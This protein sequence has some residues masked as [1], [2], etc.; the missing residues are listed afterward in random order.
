ME[1]GKTAKY[2]KY[3]IG[4]IVLV[5]IGILLAL[6]VNNWNEVRKTSIKEVKFLNGF[7]ID[8][9]ANIIELKRVIK[10]TEK[11]F[12]SS[13][14]ILQFQRGD[15]D[16]LHLQSFVVCLMNATGFT[17]Y[18]SQEGT[19]QDILGS[20]NLDVISN[21]SIRL[22]IGS[23]QANLKDLREWEKLDKN[24]HIAYNEFLINNVKVYLRG[25]TELPLDEIK[26]N[27]LLNN[28]LFLNRIQ[29]RKRYPRILNDLYNE[30]ISRLEGIITLINSELENN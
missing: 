26:M 22:A 6:Q 27:E 2:F 19:I 10:K 28:D 17:V 20:G 18:Q 25:Q 1:S 13:D 12:N 3:A 9:N 16:S 14:S 21:D 7:K 5:M 4:E 30:E 15:L 8:L 24:S 11:T 29:T 23:W